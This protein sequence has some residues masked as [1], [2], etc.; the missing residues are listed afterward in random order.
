MNGSSF[1]FFP[2]PKL[3]DQR[4]DKY[5]LSEEIEFYIKTMRVKSHLTYLMVPF[6]HKKLSQNER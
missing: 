5:L 2:I 6:N 3:S 1:T 4:K